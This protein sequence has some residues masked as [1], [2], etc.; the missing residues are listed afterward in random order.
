ME[1]LMLLL[2]ASALGEA[3]RGIFAP[4]IEFADA[5]INA[6]ERRFS[7]RHKLYAII[8]LCTL[9]AFATTMLLWL[10]QAIGR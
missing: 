4:F 1:W 9:P 3:L 10:L 5:L 6:L 8:A 2:I 7:M